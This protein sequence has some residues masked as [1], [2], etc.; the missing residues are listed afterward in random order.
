R[1]SLCRSSHADRPY[2]NRL[3]E[4]LFCGSVGAGHSFPPTLRPFAVLT[5]A[6]RFRSL[7]LAERRQPRIAGPFASRKIASDGQK[8]DSAACP[9]SARRAT[10]GSKF[11]ERRVGTHTAAPATKSRSARAITTGENPID[12]FLSTITA[13]ASRAAADAAAAPIKPP[14]TT[15]RVTSEDMSRAIAQLSAPRAF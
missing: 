2:I 12:K 3:S 7:L 11:A 6:S 1:S 8:A 14:T 4:V 5:C 13:C 10:I 9:H 15:K